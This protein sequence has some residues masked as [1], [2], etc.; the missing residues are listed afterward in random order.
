MVRC[1]MRIAPTRVVHVANDRR[2]DH[3]ADVRRQPPAHGLEPCAHPHAGA[4]RDQQHHEVLEETVGFD[5]LAGRRRRDRIGH[6]PLRQRLER[7]AGARRQDGRMA[8]EQERR[9]RAAHQPAR[10]DAGHRRRHGE[11]FRAG[12]PRLLEERR[13]R[14]AGR[15]PAGQRH[16][17]GENAHQ[18]MFAEQPGHAAADDVLQQGGDRGD[19]HHDE[20]E[21]TATREHAKAGAEADRREERVLQR[22][23]QRGVEGDERRG[24]AIDEREEGGERQPA[25]DRRGNV[26]ARQH[27]HLALDEVAEKERGPRE[28]DGLNE[29]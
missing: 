22:H 15:R 21:R 7:A 4:D 27:R 3:R 13:E 6:L 24:S 16:R 1:E 10:H 8:A 2:D 25:H 12:N 17:P 5:V 19:D 14:D 11:R 28:G 29:V 23:L 18:R 20:H 26:V 9:D